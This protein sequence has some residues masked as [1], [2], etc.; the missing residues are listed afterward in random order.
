MA[1]YD[2]VFEATNG[3][4]PITPNTSDND[5]PENIKRIMSFLTEEDFKHISEY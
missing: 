3:V 5:K 2:G 4:Q 1:M